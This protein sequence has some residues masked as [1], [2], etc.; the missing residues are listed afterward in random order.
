MLNIQ[1]D[2]NGEYCRLVDAEYKLSQ[3][4]WN[5]IINREWC[6][7]SQSYSISNDVCLT[8]INYNWFNHTSGFIKAFPSISQLDGAHIDN[9]HSTK[10]NAG[11]KLLSFVNNWDLNASK[12]EEIVEEIRE[13]GIDYEYLRQNKRYDENGFAIEACVDDMH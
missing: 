7:H 13:E 2:Y 12:I 11:D 1:V 3:N 8:R 9:A 10:K 6:K 4:K 5:I